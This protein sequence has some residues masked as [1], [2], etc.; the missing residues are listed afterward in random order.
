[1]FSTKQKEDL[2]CA[3][4]CVYRLGKGCVATPLA[5]TVQSA[6]AKS[7]LAEPG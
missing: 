3:A 5:A 6:R 1:M 7:E 2:Q 4:H